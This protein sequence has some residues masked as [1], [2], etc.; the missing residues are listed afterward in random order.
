MTKDIK[1]II[2]YLRNMTSDQAADWLMEKYPVRNNN[3]GEAII[4]MSHLS[5]K[6][7]DQLRLA[8][9][10]LSKLPFANGRPYTVFASFMKIST[11]VKVL[12]KHTPTDFSDRR[13]IE[14]YA[15]PIL[16]K[17]AKNSKDRA[18]VESFRQ[19]L[20]RTG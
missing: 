10:Y 7:E 2:D 9:H 5:W 6:K 16:E 14:Y 8:N 12:Q 18:L 4:I 20:I 17:A 19:E 3:W 13:L 15:G 1:L 11:L